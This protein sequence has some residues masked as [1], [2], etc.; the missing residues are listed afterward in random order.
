MWLRLA[1]DLLE[2]PGLGRASLEKLRRLGITSQR[3]LLEHLPRRYIDRGGVTPI[4]SVRDGETAT[5]VGVV[6]RAGVR[7]SRR[8]GL[9]IV[10]AVL[11]DETGRIGLVWFFQGP[12]GKRAARPP[13]REGRRIAAWGKVRWTP[14]GPEIQNPQ[15]EEVPAAAGTGI[16][17][18][19]HP[20]YP[21]GQGLSQAQL[22]RWIH[23]VL[24]H[25]PPAETLSE[26]TRRRRGLI[27]LAEAFEKLHRPESL[28]DVEAGRRRLAFEELYRLLLEMMAAARARE[29]TR[30]PRCPREA[31]PPEE[32]EARLPFA[33]T[34]AQRRAIERCSEMLEQ[35]HATSALLQG[36]VGSGKT[37]V[38]AYMAA[39][40]VLSGYQAAI[41]APTRLLAEQH[42]NNLAGLLAP[43]GIEIDLLVSGVTP[44]Q[45]RE[46]VAR[47]EAGEPRVVVGTH[48]LLSSEIA[49]PR[50]AVGVVDE[51]HRFGVEQRERLSDKGPGHLLLMSATPI[52]RTL[53]LTLYADLELIALDEKPPGRKPVDTRWIHP[54]DREKVYAF[55][56]REVEQGR[57]AYVVFPRVHAGGDDEDAESAVVQ[58]EE[59]AATWLR[60][61]R[62]G[63][64]HGQMRPAE[65]EAVMARFARGETDVLVATTVVEV[66]V[67]V[68]RAS[69]M[70]VEGADRFG[71]AQLHQ[72]RGRVGRGPYAS[73][74][75]LVADPQTEAAKRRIDALRK[76][77]DGFAIAEMDL[78]LR[79]PGELA[80]VKQAGPLEFL[81][82][83]FPKDLD[84]AAAAREE[85]RAAL[86]GGAGGGGRPWSG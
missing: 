34:G 45:R 9:Y 42:A 30:A 4:R 44:A 50:F 68:P 52:P 10:E 7:E 1:G 43:W 46:V 59:L 41:M 48:A 65:Q 62:V 11:R 83:E 75:L 32:Y 77:D 61:V 82:A 36:D 20:V 19:P 5:V 17:L 37:V 12:R 63:L 39:R 55:V 79:G 76:T 85:A 72:L 67:D 22:R 14:R 3:Q 84:L 21:A 25:R 53:A 23:W 24:D 56:R 49:M 16:S 26:A 35:P 8:R 60:G 33:L 15:W 51:Q 64:L 78:A 57:Q 40:A 71:L 2:I 47:L 38:A 13:V 54:R 27:G 31:L 74:C 66:G 81:A 6:E 58:A 80:G 29:T 18:A 69:V 70:V 73:Y 28:E 86:D